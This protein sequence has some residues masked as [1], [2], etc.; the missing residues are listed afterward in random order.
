MKWNEMKSMVSNFKWIEMKWNH[1]STVDVIKM[2]F[3]LDF[4]GQEGPSENVK[5]EESDR[6]ENKKGEK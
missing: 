2:N 6:E 5:M 1:F 3:E 4:I